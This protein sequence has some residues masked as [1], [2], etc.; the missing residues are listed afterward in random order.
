MDTMSS[1]RAGV[2][3][4]LLLP[5]SACLFDLAPL[6]PA[7]T[8]GGGAAG[9]GGSAPSG[10]EVLV[11]YDGRRVPSLQTDVP[12]LVRLDADRID[13]GLTSDDGNDLRFFTEDGATPLPHEIERWSPGG[14]SIV[15]VRLPVVEPAG[16]AFRMRFGDPDAGA[17]PPASQVW[18]RYAGVYHFADPNAAIARDSAKTHDGTATGVAST[19]GRLGDGFSFDGSTSEVTVGEIAAF[20]VPPG[21]AR[22]FSVWFRRDTTEAAAMSLGRTKNS[23]CDGWSLLILG[24]QYAN[25]RH[26]VTIGSCCTGTADDYFTNPV[27]LP[28]GQSDVDWHRVTAV[29]DRDAGTTTLYL[30]A[31]EIASD[32]L[33]TTGAMAGQD[34]AFGVGESGA[35]HFLGILDE[36]RVG[37]EAF[38]TEWVTLTYDIALDQLLNFGTVQQR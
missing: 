10:Y 21:Q 8:G 17:P 18:S 3:A 4:S 29:M 2:L 1:L 5:A 37:T 14:T 34:V 38:S 22:S 24:D 35:D 32:P 36:A 12:V 6:E 30:D 26:D 13:Y 15:W 23:C 31:V 20:D 33:G 19:V 25:L 9:T 16:G 7:G 27:A 11:S 28:S